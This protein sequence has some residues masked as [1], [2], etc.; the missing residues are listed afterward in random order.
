MAVYKRKDRDTWVARLSGPNGRLVQKGRRAGP[1]RR[2]TRNRL[3]ERGSHPGHIRRGS[4]YVAASTHPVL[5][6]A[7]TAAGAV[8]GLALF[9]IA[10]EH[11]VAECVHVREVSHS[12][13]QPGWSG[14][15][16]PYSVAARQ[17]AGCST[18]CTVEAGSAAR[19]TVAGEHR[20]VAGWSARRGGRARPGSQP[21]A[22]RCTDRAACGCRPGRGRSSRGERG[23]HRT[24]EC[25]RA[26]R[27]AAGM[28][29]WTGGRADWWASRTFCC[30][31]RLSGLASADPGCRRRPVQTR[32]DWDGCYV[33]VAVG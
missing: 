8:A 16:P 33:A 6:A 9:S 4:V 15:P 18:R 19:G 14:C 5:T 13:A 26:A 29:W 3:R 1:P 31:E 30:A 21:R 32:R 10:P 7:G 11:G 22:A 23:R 20:S 28:W 17:W 27:A 24:A 25:P 12:E 2:P